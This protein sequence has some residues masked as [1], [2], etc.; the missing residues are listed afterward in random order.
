VSIKKQVSTFF[1]IVVLAISSAALRAAESDF[2]VP[3]AIRPAIGFWIK[4]YTEADTNS[5]F[6]HDNTNLAIIYTK[7]PRDRDLIDSTRKTIAADLEVLA[8][9]KRNGLT[10]AQQKLLE[11][12]GT[13]TSN[14]AF[15]LASRSIRWQLG[16]SDRFQEGLRRSGAYREHIEAVTRE[17]GVP[18]ELAALPHVESSFHPGAFSSAAASGMWQFVRETAQ[19][20]MRVDTVVDERLDP[21]KATYGALELL[22]FNY[23]ALGSWPLALTAYN[24]GTNGMARAVRDTASRDIGEIITKYKGPRFGFASRNFYPQFL[25]ALEVDRNA[26]KYFGPIRKDTS[27]QFKQYAMTGFV[28]A[29]V[30]ARSLGVS[31]DV[32]KRD[33]PALLP[34]IWSGNKRIP[35]GYTL[36][37]DRRD[38]NGDLVASIGG[39][40]AADFFNAQIPDV[41]YTVRSG[42]SLSVIA[43]RYNTSVG[44]LM[45][46]NQL[47][48]RNRIRVGQKLILPQANGAVPTV[49]VASNEPRT[50]PAT[51]RY[52]V[53]RG[54]TVFVI[55]QRF[56]VEASTLMAMNQL[57]E[58]AL[59]YP[60]QELLLASP[61]P[62]P[63]TRQV[64]V[65]N[66]QE[67]SLKDEIDEAL[68]E[69]A[70]AAAVSNAIATA[71]SPALDA[72][73]EVTEAE[74]D[75]QQELVLA[76]DP[77]NY[78]VDRNDSIEILA[79]ETLGHYA[80][81]LGILS[82]D[83]RRMNNMRS[84]SPVVLGNRIKLDFSKVS[85][86]DFE[87]KRRQYH[88]DLQSRY[89]ASW[90][91]LET[92]NYSIKRRDI[93]D[94][95]TRQRSIPMWLFLQY[96]PQVLDTS[97]LQIGQEVIFPVVERVTN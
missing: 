4:V 54:D 74:Q 1:S 86:T 58:R 55:A 3:D 95:L 28:D 79:E 53:Q 93:L 23:E 84:T 87:R 43:D 61:A 10:A 56:G 69:A 34:A 21:Y 20:F 52:E 66:P 63:Q 14:E 45:A 62:Q 27:P 70:A 24:H 94:N 91:I 36:K 5:G 37:I 42:D 60:G 88:T 75:A 78:G 8:S 49:L 31:V 19:R 48:D 47:R 13:G 25:A 68:D 16:Q 50:V 17:K 40:P 72:N 80:E 96:N 41:S 44:E 97:T 81:W 73:A 18:V 2:P 64:A 71:N 57:D 7:L 82:A 59:I 85:R 83:L 29:A 30:M 11:Q 32:L 15:D 12:W 35:K 38:F 22:K 65:A 6:L 67:V 92:E 90:R 89:F 39:I 9:G 51:G 77:L 76:S 46:I 33:N 26:D